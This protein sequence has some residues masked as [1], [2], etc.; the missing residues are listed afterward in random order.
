MR[1]TIVAV[2]ALKS[3]PCQELCALYAQRLK[4]GRPLGPL[5]VKE[6]AERRAQSPEKQKQDDSARLLAAVPEGAKLVV[7]DERGTAIGSRAFAKLLERWRDEGTRET[8]FLIGGAEGHSESLKQR[9]DHLLSLGALTWPHELAR[10][11]LAEQLYRA[12]CILS[13]HPYHRD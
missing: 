4:P 7:L 8:A 10:A 11:M 5:S 9:A 3:A 12:N 13:G 6:V 1:L 2:G